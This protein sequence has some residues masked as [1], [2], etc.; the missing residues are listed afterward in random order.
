M[1]D[2]SD[3]S[4]CL[5]MKYNEAWGVLVQR[6]PLD[7]GLSNPH[8]VSPPSAYF[9]LAVRLMVVG[10][11]TK[12]WGPTDD[13]C[14]GEPLGEDPTRRLMDVYAEFDLGRRYMRSPFWQAAHRL[15]EG[16]NPG[17]PR[18]AF[19]WSNLVKIDQCGHRPGD[20]Y[21]SLVTELQLLQFEITQLDPHVVVFF[22]GPRYRDRLASTFPQSTRERVDA[23]L[24][25]IKLTPTSTVMAWETYHPGY[26]R[27]DKARWTVLDRIVA[28]SRSASSEL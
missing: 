20:E 2:F 14:F 7:R 19:L 5:Y 18:G 22:T 6:L 28:L 1:S 23:L 10:Q 11:E 17:H 26:L 3:A 9:E 15:H 24:T 27:R 8:F 4:S 13:G 25:R 21:E 16:L 12:G